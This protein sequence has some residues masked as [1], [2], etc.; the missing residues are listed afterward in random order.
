MSKA[1]TLERGESYHG[2]RVRH[3]PIPT[4]KPDEVLL[5]MRAAALNHRDL[6]IRQGLYP[7]ISF[8]APLL[9]DGCGVVLAHPHASR[10]LAPGTRV[11]VNPGTGWAADPAGPE[12]FYAVIGG[13]TATPLGTLQTHA[14]VPAADVAPAPAHLSDAEAAALPLAGLTA[15]RA[16]VTKSGQALP[17]HN[18]LITGIGGGVALM[19]LAFAVAK[20]CRVFVTSASREKIDRARELGAA[21]GVLYSDDD[22]PRTLKGVLPRDRPWLDAVID[23][24]GGDVVGSTWRLLKKGGVLVSYGQTTLGAPTLPMQAVMKNL[25]LKGTTMGSRREFSEMLDFVAEKKI[26]PAVDKIVEWTESLD[27]IENLFE[28]MFSSKQFGKLVVRIQGPGSE[29]ITSSKL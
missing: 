27:G 25:E 18:I 29:E 21:G 23:G 9:A 26:R 2:L 14:A 3:A 10:A 20:G 11:L 15:W 28:D 5:Q 22:W 8:D 6:F 4:P 16:L 12:G 17:D 24:A 13:S 1:V 7:G 19:A